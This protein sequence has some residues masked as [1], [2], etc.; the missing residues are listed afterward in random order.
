MIPA[1]WNVTLHPWV[2]STRRFGLRTLEDEGDMFL[3]NVGNH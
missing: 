1:F 2:T 3:R